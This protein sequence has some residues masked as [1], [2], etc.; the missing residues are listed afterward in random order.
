MNFFATQQK[1]AAVSGTVL[2]LVPLL[3]LPPVA[4]E[5]PSVYE[6]SKAIETS[7]DKAWP[8]VLSVVTKNGFTP[9]LSDRAGGVLK[10]RFTRGD[11]LYGGARNDMN[12]LTLKPLSRWSVIERFRIESVV[13]TVAGADAACQVTMQVRYAAWRNNLAEKGWVG[14]ESNG[15]LEWMMLAE[16][17][18]FAA[19]GGNLPT[20][21][22]DA[23]RVRPETPTPVVAA[24]GNDPKEGIVIR[25]T[26]NPAGAEVDVDGEY[27]GSAPATLTRLA[28]GAHTIMVKKPGYQNWERKITLTPGDNRTLNAELEAKPN[29]PTKP[30]II[31]LD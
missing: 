27:W 15:R 14:L 6:N 18:R 10:A 13:V 11:S 8:V 1:R 2:I 22:N 24:R 19:A 31:G 30:H 3:T 17:E 25:V 16:T 5:N 21:S 20:P 9:E 26:S 23:K 29:D 4:A 12:T 7:C 28:E